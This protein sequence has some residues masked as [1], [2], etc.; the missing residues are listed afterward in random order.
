[1][2]PELSVKISA[3]IDLLRDNF[4]KAI[5]NVKNFDKDTK[6]ALSSVD[7]GF[8]R[9]ANDIDKD[10]SRAS[11]SVNRTSSSI[12]KSLAQQAVA[13][14]KSRNTYL[15]F[16]R[17]LQDLPY[18][19]TGIQNNLTQLVPAA[20]AAGLA[21]S[22]LISLLTFA[23]VGT[24]NWTRGLKGN[25]TALDA[26]ALSGDEYIETLSQI[27]AVRLK[28]EQNSAKEITELKVLYQAYQ[29]ANLPLKVRQDAYK[30]IQD[31]YPAYFKNIKF[32]QEAS[33][34][35][36]AAYE[37]LTLAILASGRARAAIDKITENE[38]RKLENAQK[39][40]DLDRERTEYINKQAE[41]LKKRAAD[42]NK[43]YTSEQESFKITQK[44][45]S[46]QIGYIYQSDKVKNLTS[47]INNLKTDTNKLDEKS[48]QLL[49]LVNTDLQK[50]AQ[51]IKSVGS[52]E[53]V[54][55]IAKVLNGNTL[56]A[57]GGIVPTGLAPTT[58]PI[59]NVDF[60][61]AKQINDGFLPQ[62]IKLIQEASDANDK[63]VE[64]LNSVATSALSSGIGD[65]FASIGMALAD[66][67][68]AIEAFGTALLDAFAGFLSQLGQ[69][70]IKEGIAQ[71][72]Y[73]IAKNL[74]LP[75]SGI[76]NISGGTAMIA[77][78]AGI[79]VLGGALRGGKGGGSQNR[80]A[81]PI[82]GFASGVN[83]FSGGMALVGERGAELVNLPTGASVMNNNRTNQILKDNN[84]SEQVQVFG[85]VGFDMDKFVIKFRNTEN[86]L[87][88]Q[89]A[90]S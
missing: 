49:E 37:G 18:G 10:M 53:K 29:N 9:L 28:G 8:E 14:S 22:A 4:R 64:S 63:F 23:T 82:K 47:Q 30:D 58:T 42:Q 56:G 51:I 85:E 38:S 35:T 60:S 11:A 17:V 54:K 83:N 57:G 32:E 39:A 25:K 24:D 62:Y 6:V 41:I 52:L 90:F 44:A 68:N 3:D 50:G 76:N 70:F 43:L 16:G 40:T 88:R 73:G 13:T 61:K 67:T 80:Q 81:T 15:E 78:G 84:R 12:T 27:N 2:T 79:S 89:G 46:T 86:R 65:A 7:K 34:R 5:V 36:K 55:E 21:F 77:A 66:G 31:L 20:G 74:I 69:M 19:F 59:A 33:E 87:K 45:I 48:L 72:G 71:I 75:G 26:V 1:M